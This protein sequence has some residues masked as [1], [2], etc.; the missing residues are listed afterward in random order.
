M[1]P[2]S[3]LS[4][5]FVTHP[6]PALLDDQQSP[7]GPVR[8]NFYPQSQITLAA[9]MAQQGFDVRVLDL[10]SLDAP[11]TW[12]SQL[13]EA[14]AEPIQYGEIKLHRHLIGPYRDTIAKSERD[15]DVYA[16]TANF[17]YEAASVRKTIQLL[18]AHNPDAVIMV[19]GRDASAKERWSY[20]IESGADYVGEGD[21]D[22]SLARFLHSL[23]AERASGSRRR[24]LPMAE[25]RVIA[26]DP[27]EEIAFIDLDA[28]FPDFSRVRPRLN[29]SGG[30]SVL[31]SIAARGFAAYVETSRGCPRECDFCTEA[32]TKSLRLDLPSLRRQVDHFVD[33]GASLL[34]F[35]DDNLLTRKEAD[36]IQIFGYLRE[37][38]TSWEFPVGLE[39]E[40]LTDSKG[41]PKW[42]L[43]KAL[44]WNNGDRENWAGAHRMLFPVEDSLLRAT[45]LSKLR[46]NTYVQIL[47]ALIDRGL[48]FVNM[49]IMIGGPNETEDERSRLEERLHD[50]V[51]LFE[52]K[53]T[54]LNFSIFCT[55]P[56]PGTEFAAR[57][58]REERVVYDIQHYPELWSVFSSVVH[59][60]NFRPEASTAYRRTLLAR[61]NMQQDSGK[62]Q[63]T[64]D[65]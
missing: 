27:V 62:V 52:G 45:S 9:T 21:A 8:T 12:K 56:L 2:E 47:E 1:T 19:G 20:F 42:D 31:P 41:Q 6:C 44:F 24:R 51:R 10:R 34:M 35:S 38:G 22:T 50:F 54:K 30:G 61:H 16:L 39:V 40:N 26:A 29:E 13:G 15:V 11:D 36:L 7:Y 3:P 37:R 18:R 32:R 5:C 17:T 28:V 4:V 53:A 46:K 43:I 60:N 55:M 23:A 14:Y 57:M 64:G 65:R 58:R 63:V 48:P 33:H 59:G 25:A 49:A